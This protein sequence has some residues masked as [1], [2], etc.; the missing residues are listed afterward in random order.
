[1]HVLTHIYLINIKLKFSKNGFS[2]VC[3]TLRTAT[4]NKPKTRQ[5]Y[6]CL[7]LATNSVFNFSTRKGFL[8]AFLH[9]QIL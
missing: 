4:S 9:F 6:T 5:Y 3:L 7:T 2:H 1:M 8:F